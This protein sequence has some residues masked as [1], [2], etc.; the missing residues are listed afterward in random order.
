MYAIIIVVGIVPLRLIY[1]SLSDT[2]ST[3]SMYCERLL[4]MM[5]AVPAGNSLPPPSPSKI[6]VNCVLDSLIWWRT[7]VSCSP[8]MFC[9]FST[10]AV[11]LH[12][13]HTLSVRP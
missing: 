3:S 9:C 6:H 4:C 5:F 1:F 8:N 13:L 2:G 12:L 10:S 7:L 11:R